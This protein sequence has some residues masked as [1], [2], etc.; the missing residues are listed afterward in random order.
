[1]LSTRLTIIAFLA[2]A[3]FWTSEGK[4]YYDV[5][6]PGVN[7]E[8][9]CPQGRLIEVLSMQYGKKSSVDCAARSQ[10]A[11]SVRAQ[12]IHWRMIGWVKS[13][14]D[15]LQRCRLPKPNVQMFI[16]NKDKDNFIQY[17]YKCNIKSPDVKTAVFCEGQ[18]ALIECP[19]GRLN[20]LHSTFGRFDE[21]ICT[22]RASTMTFCSSPQAGVIKKDCDGYRIC[23]FLSNS[24]Y[25]G[26]PAFCDD[27]PKYTTVDYVCQ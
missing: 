10:P 18:K 17:K 5:A 1:M 16:C 3:W 24:G 8:L 12:C 20:I 4:I 6:C 21:Y 7:S 11:T 15:N 19:R 13:I 23:K 25:L 27:L 2:A 14:C 26:K 22:D 9:R